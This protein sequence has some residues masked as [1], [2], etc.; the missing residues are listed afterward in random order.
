MMEINVAPGHVLSD[1]GGFR[2]KRLGDFQDMGFP[3]ECSACRT[4]PIIY[5]HGAK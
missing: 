2:P 5:N 4:I 1:I 3:E